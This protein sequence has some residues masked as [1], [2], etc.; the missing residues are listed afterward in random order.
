MDFSHSPQFASPNRQGLGRQQ[1]GTRNPPRLREYQRGFLTTCWLQLQVEVKEGLRRMKEL[2]SMRRM[3]AKRKRLE[4]LRNGRVVKDKV[5]YEEN[6][7]ENNSYN[8]EFN[9]RINANGNHM[10]SL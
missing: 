1:P 2:Q 7:C 10:P 6:S 4:K 3:E 5:D 8:Y 9:G